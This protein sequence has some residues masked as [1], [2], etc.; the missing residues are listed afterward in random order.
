MFT[1]VGQPYNLH[2]LHYGNV[3]IYLVVCTSVQH[4]D[5]VWST[6][7]LTKIFTGSQDT[8]DLTT[9]STTITS[10]EDGHQFTEDRLFRC[11]V[12]TFLKLSQCGLENA[13]HVKYFNVLQWV[14]N[15]S[16]YYYLQWRNQNFERGLVAEGPRTISVPICL[17]L[18]LV[19]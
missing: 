2:A 6:V 16:Y 5:P 10:V 9:I 4:L 18:N 13:K 15:I 12:T 7:I 3:K 19:L 8:A 14:F 11:H 17:K 1:L